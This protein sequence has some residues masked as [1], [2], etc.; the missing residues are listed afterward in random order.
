MLVVIAII[1]ILLSFLL[2]S[3]TRAKEKAKRSVCLSNLAQLHRGT[4]GFAKDNN[5]KLPIGHSTHSDHNGFYAVK[6]ANS[7]Y[8]HGMAYKHG[9]LTNGKVFYC[10]S[11][12]HSDHKFGNRKRYGGLQP[13]GVAI[14]RIATN[15]YVY[16]DTFMN[17]L[18]TNRH[19]YNRHKIRP[20]ILA[21]DDP[22]WSLIADQVADNYAVNWAHK[23]GHNVVFLGGHAKWNNDSSLLLMNLWNRSYRNHE[24]KFFR[25]LD[26]VN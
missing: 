11:S 6:V 20:G 7:W 4:M 5:G 3:I 26:D 16:R 14:P 8:G 15:S 21:K 13:P 25:K 12:T 9:Y 17:S 2:P 10:P 1:A 24:E 19:Y 18:H 22:N 23:Q